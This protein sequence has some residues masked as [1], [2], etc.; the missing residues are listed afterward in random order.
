MSTNLLHDNSIEASET[1][2][3]MSTSKE[4]GTHFLIEIALMQTNY[5]C[6]IKVTHDP[7][8]GIP[9][10]IVPMEPIDIL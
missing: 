1:T 3:S 7:Q 10:G 6:N 8:N 9:Q 2:T 5:G 4:N